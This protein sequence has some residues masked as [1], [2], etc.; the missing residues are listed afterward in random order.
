MASLNIGSVKQEDAES[1]VPLLEMSATGELLEVKEG[2]R[3]DEVQVDKIR[4]GL[5]DIFNLL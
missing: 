5:E 2:E 3:A 1:G 4:K